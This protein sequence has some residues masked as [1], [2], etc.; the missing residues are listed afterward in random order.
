MPPRIRGYH[1]IAIVVSDLERSERF[2]HDVLGMK[3]LMRIPGRG[4]TMMLGEGEYQF[5]GLWLP[6]Q[7]GSSAGA[8]YGKIHFVMAIDVADTAA[9]YEHLRSHSVNVQKRIKENGD[10]HLD[11]DDPD[12]HPLEF[13]GRTGSLAAMPGADVPPERRHMFFGMG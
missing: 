3:V 2:Y 12:G 10:S 5:L 8:E 11:F 7:H 13:W 4:V 1:E 9:W 6:N